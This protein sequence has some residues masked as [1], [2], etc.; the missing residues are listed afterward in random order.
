MGSCTAGGAYVPAMSDENVIV[1]RQG[2]IFLGGP[3]L[4]KAATGETVSA[5][6]LGGADLHCKTSGV[7]DHYA[8]SDEHALDITKKIVRNLNIVKNPQ[9]GR[10]PYEEPLY[11]AEELYGIV[12]D[13]LMKNYD[14]REVCAYI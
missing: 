9:I 4:V 13:N 11:A 1:R 14:V 8:L 6:N 10:L 7:T 12:S 2:T 3:P 5:E